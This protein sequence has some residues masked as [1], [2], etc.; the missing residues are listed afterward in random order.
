MH[1][2]SVHCELYADESDNILEEVTESELL[3]LLLKRQGNSLICFPFGYTKLHILLYY[4]LQ[5]NFHNDSKVFSFVICGNRY[6]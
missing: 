4:I 2:Q 1:T 6:F 5:R 3:T